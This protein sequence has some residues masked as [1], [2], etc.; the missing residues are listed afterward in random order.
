MT[1]RELINRLEA[2]SNNGRRD[3]MTVMLHVDGY[4]EQDCYGQDECETVDGACVDM[5]NNCGTFDESDDSYEFIK[6]YTKAE[7]IT[8]I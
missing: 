8:L 4:M 6:I 3:Q 7:Y 1:L 2:L 5:Y